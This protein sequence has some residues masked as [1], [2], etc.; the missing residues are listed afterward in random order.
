MTYSHGKNKFASIDS[1]YSRGSNFFSNY[2]LLY[3]NA[4]LIPRLKVGKK[5]IKPI[6]MYF[7]ATNFFDPC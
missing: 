2:R 7:L 1:Q 5:L 6:Y 4:Q 3:S